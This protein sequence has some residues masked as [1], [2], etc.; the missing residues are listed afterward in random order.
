MF[1]RPR[2]EIELLRAGLAAAAGFGTLVRASGARLTI[3]Y[4]ATLAKRE[5]RPGDL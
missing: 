4:S 3:T 2:I 1:G 5:E